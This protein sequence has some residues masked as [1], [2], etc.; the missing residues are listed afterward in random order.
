MFSKISVTFLCKSV[1]VYTHRLLMYIRF[2]HGMCAH[3]YMTCTYACTTFMWPH[4]DVK[5][6]LRLTLKPHIAARAHTQR[7]QKT[8]G[9]Y[10]H[11]VRQRFAFF[12]L[13]FFTG[14]RIRI[15]T[16]A[17]THATKGCT[18]NFVQVFGKYVVVKF[19]PVFT[20]F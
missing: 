11:K 1:C 4:I 18:K 17:A 15:D 5:C 13:V 12:H 14:T 6:L 3:T 19:C 7:C 16:T 9:S 8:P 20:V 2:I 10:L